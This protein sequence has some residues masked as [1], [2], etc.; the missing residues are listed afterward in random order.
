MVGIEGLSEDVILTWC[1]RLNSVETLCQEVVSFLPGDYSYSY[2]WQKEN[3]S[4]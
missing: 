3:N 4:N 1:E 2:L